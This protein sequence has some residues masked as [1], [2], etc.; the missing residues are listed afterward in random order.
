[1][2]GVGQVNIKRPS[3]ASVAQ[4]VQDAMGPAT[5]PR[6]GTAVRTT[7]AAGLSPA[8][9]DPSRREVL[10]PRDPLGRIRNVLARPVHD[11]FSRRS[12]SE[13]NIGQ[14]AP[15]TVDFRNNDATVSISWRHIR[16]E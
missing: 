15:K 4:V 14:S 12:A 6:L 9:L 8:P 2:R 3:A 11:R 1:M 5:A 7:A 16:S 10:H 13:E